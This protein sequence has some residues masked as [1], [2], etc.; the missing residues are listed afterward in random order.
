MRKK[1]KG[2]RRVDKISMSF[3]GLQVLNNVDL[4]LEQS[5]LLGLI[6]PN[7]AGKSTLF[8]IITTIYK[9]NRGEV[10]LR[11]QKIT[12]LPPHKICRIGI[13]R[14]F[15]LIKTFLSMTVLENVMVGS[16]YGNPHQ[17]KEARKR[18]LEALDLVEL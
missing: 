18:A 11:G 4:R 16:I 6:G 17:G 10:Y 3:G 15:Q 13:A 1:N 7:G 12:G 5:E 8:N 14:T 9:P 2:I